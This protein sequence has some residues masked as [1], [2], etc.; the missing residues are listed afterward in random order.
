MSHPPVAA[1]R[2]STGGGMSGRGLTGGRDEQALRAENE[3]APH[4]PDLWTRVGA[5]F[6]PYRRQLVLTA[7]LVVVAASATIIPPL[8]TERIFDDAL[9]PASGEPNITLL[10]ELVAAM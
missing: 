9:F 4:I 7:A 8:L 2:P 1:R 3:A 5:L 10:A 6:R